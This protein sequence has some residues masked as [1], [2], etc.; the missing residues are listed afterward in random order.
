MQVTFG[1]R[2]DLEAVREQI[3]IGLEGTSRGNSPVPMQV[4]GR[5]SSKS[6]KRSGERHCLGVNATR[7]KYYNYG[8]NSSAPVASV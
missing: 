7:R 3:K 8:R 4:D 6:K 1:S 5:S 2:G